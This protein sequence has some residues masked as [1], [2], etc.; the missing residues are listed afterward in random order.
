MNATD[1]TFRVFISSTF[2]DM[3]SERNALHE[4]TWPRLQ[5]YCLSQGCRFQAIDLRWGVSEEAALD[6]QTMPLCLGEI[7]RCR[8]VTP[9]PNFV[10][11][12]GAR[13][14][15]RPLPWEV[16]AGEFDELAAAL[17][18]AEEASLLRDWY[19]RDDNAVPPHYYLRAR[20]Q[21]IPAGSDAE[22]R[23]AA[24]ESE[25]EQWRET[26]A[27][28]HTAFQRAM[29][30]LG[31]QRWDAAG[32][33]PGDPRRSPFERS[34]TEHEVWAG[35]L[36]GGDGNAFAYF[37]TH[38]TAVASHGDAPFTDGA[39]RLDALKAT[40][41]HRLG[42]RARDY[43]LRS[44]CDAHRETDLL[45]L[46]DMVYEDLKRV[47]DGEIGGASRQSATEEEVARHRALLEAPAPCLRGRQAPLQAVAEYTGS[48]SRAPLLLHGPPGVGKTSVML[49]AI[50]AAA[51]GNAAVVYRFVG[52]TPASTDR[53]E[54]IA[55]LCRQIR[56]QYDGE[57]LPLPGEYRE[58]VGELDA[59]LRLAHP[60]RPLLL[61]V[62]AVDR[63]AGPPALGWLPADLPDHVH[64][65]LSL[66]GATGG[67]T[68]CL[69]AARRR[70]P[71]ARFV[72][73]NGLVPADCEAF[74]DDRLR[75]SGRTLQN[76]QRRHTVDRYVHS[77]LP[78]YMSLAFEQVRAWRSPPRDGPEALS[79]QRLAEDVPGLVI[80][81]LA[82][83]R[84][85]QVHGSQLVARALGYLAASRHGLSEDELLDV[86]SRDPVVYGEFLGGCFH[87][88][89]DLR[90]CIE[91]HLACAG[92][93]QTPDEFLLSLTDAPDR[94]AQFAAEALARAPELRIPVAL[95]ARLSSDLLPYLIRRAADGAVV[96]SLRQRQFEDL[97]RE[98]FLQ[99][100]HGRQRHT[101]LA[102][103]F[104][105]SPLW[106]SADREHGAN[107][108]KLA[109][110]PYQQAAAEAWPDLAETLADVPFVEAACLS[111]RAQALSQD[112]LAAERAMQSAGYSPDPPP[113]SMRAAL[114]EAL[115]P[116]ARATH[117]ALQILYRRLWRDTRWGRSLREC[118]S[119]SGRDLVTV[120]D[121]R[122][123]GAATPLLQL[124]AQ[125]VPA[126]CT[127][128]SG[129]TLLFA[130]SPRQSGP[131]AILAASFSTDE[132]DDSPVGCLPHAFRPA[133]A[134]CVPAADRMALCDPN[135]GEVH[136]VDIASGRTV[137]T[138]AAGAAAAH[139]TAIPGRAGAASGA[140]VLTLQRG[141][142]ALWPADGPRAHIEPEEGC[143]FSAALD[144]EMDDAEYTLWALG[145]LDDGRWALFSVTG[146]GASGAPT[147]SHLRVWPCAV[148]AWDADRATGTLG[149][150]LADGSLE[151]VSTRTGHLQRVL[152]TPDACRAI[153]LAQE[154]DLIVIADRQ[155]AIH[156]T[157]GPHHEWRLLAQGI[158]G[159]KSLVARCV[160][161]RLSV[162]IGG[163]EGLWIAAV[164]D[165]G[166]AVA[167]P[168]AAV[169]PGAGGLP[170]AAATSPSGQ[171]VALGGDEV[172]AV[173]AHSG[174]VLWRGTPA[175]PGRTAR[176][177]FAD[178]D[179][180]LVC[181]AN[182]RLCEYDART[183]AMRGQVDLGHGMAW[184]L[185]VA[186][187]PNALLALASSGAIVPGTSDRSFFL[188]YPA[189]STAVQVAV[190]PNVIRECALSPGGQ[191][192]VL[193]EIDGTAIPHCGGGHLLHL[194]RLDIAAGSMASLSQFPTAE[195]LDY[196]NAPFALDAE[197][198]CFLTQSRSVVRV[199]VTDDGRWQETAAREDG[200]Y[201][202][203]AA[204]AGGQMVLATAEG[205]VRV[206]DRRL[207]TVTE[208]SVGGAP[209]LATIRTDPRC[210][211]MLVVRETSVE[212]WR[213]AEGQA[214]LSAF[215]PTETTPV[216]LD[217]AKD[218][219]VV[220]LHEPN[221]PPYWLRWPGE[222]QSGREEGRHADHG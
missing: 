51:Q 10:V 33:S 171:M 99:G 85:P 18:D 100:D 32:D 182:G 54:F 201:Q 19:T 71:T 110:L 131:F 80:D 135:T 178:A 107:L 216:R 78:L 222:P 167:T 3:E 63:L 50:R 77:G 194:V 120:H 23:K 104:I 11:L 147:L 39:A 60:L 180:L 165:T 129:R 172:T 82:R 16:P 68:P 115:H 160:D 121:L 184:C 196:L 94:A 188:A 56:A 21:P 25:A 164:D 132:A 203:L 73:L 146:R 87:V 163:P 153:A 97:V 142:V 12:L 140:L 89:P 44:D 88:P 93:P 118:A 57:E 205:A 108:R 103:H 5:A 96:L 1:R 211:T 208:C 170:V 61:F 126:L 138:L 24:V 41:R 150:A 27:S 177:S 218:L 187:T 157:G 210:G 166:R 141:T 198:F 98:T 106:P 9:R 6:Q 76:G 22:T 149:V 52:A 145:G 47:I 40:L 144:G 192:A 162:A 206:C 55:G 116:I 125:C 15:W 92:D 122:P 190:Y 28:L 221:A 2:S 156:W 134:T 213:S 67:E 83:L 62:D 139:L 58:L 137:R 168:S 143:Y 152:S 46:C 212:W 214:R 197:G 176:L 209:G 72:E 14:G 179:T 109:E 84:A 66:D 91:G 69:L 199:D 117:A 70:W 161:G 26:E 200:P 65:V 173:E 151:L 130:A 90:P 113:A 74:L 102:E 35:A 4:R 48:V 81:L 49:E 181:T 13:Y 119:A 53:V 159:A 36:S 31:W 29:E 17:G 183:G 38:N 124:T 207:R 175:P 215:V 127:D 30:R 111:G 123:G 45:S 20:S 7:E 112:M 59:C 37:R 105:R 189:Q 43:R 79:T 217:A 136:E 202:A 158:P 8:Q 114:R 169:A 86:L 34:A 193:H 220:V 195:G 64:V 75:A 128:E 154:T 42:E 133:T 95:W 204:G 219:S 148:T 186:P 155:G 101:R 174:E 191:W 185:G